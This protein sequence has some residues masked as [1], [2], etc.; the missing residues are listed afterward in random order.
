M[1]MVMVIRA[2]ELVDARLT[3]TCCHTHDVSPD[4]PNSLLV[5]LVNNGNGVFVDQCS[6]IHPTHIDRETT[7]RKD[8][9]GDGEAFEAMFGVVHM[10]SAQDMLAKLARQGYHL[11]RCTPAESENGAE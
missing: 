4:V 3:L 6:L 8:D 2:P 1:S 11:T 5:E 7:T 10:E 9:I